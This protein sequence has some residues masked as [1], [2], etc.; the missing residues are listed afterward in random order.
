MPDKMRDSA[1]KQDM[2]LGRQTH[3][4]AKSQS[5]GTESQKCPVP[6]LIS[7]KHLSVRLSNTPSLMYFA[8]D[9]F[10]NQLFPKL[11]KQLS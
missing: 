4:G 9:N 3:F 11:K 10:S 7:P 1:I 8:F 5:E 2:E 6:Y